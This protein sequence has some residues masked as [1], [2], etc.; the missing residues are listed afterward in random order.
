MVG[1]VPAFDESRGSSLIRMIALRGTGHLASGDRRSEK[2]EGD[3]GRE[4]SIG[5]RKRHV[6][7]NSVSETT[8]RRPARRVGDIGCFFSGIAENAYGCP[9]VSD[10]SVGNRRNN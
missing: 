8:R 6:V 2:E 7:V 10:G 4:D 9:S 3:E 5:D 1:V